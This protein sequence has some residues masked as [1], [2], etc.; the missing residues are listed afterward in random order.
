MKSVFYNDIENRAYSIY[1]LYQEG[2][3]SNTKELKMKVI[4]NNNYGGRT[5]STTENDNIEVY[6]GT[7]NVC[8]E[9]FTTV[10][11]LKTR[12]IVDIIFRNQKDINNKEFPYEAIIFDDDGK[13]RLIDSKIRD[14]RIV[15][16][17]IIFCSR[18]ILS[19]EIGHLFNGHCDYVKNESESLSYL[20]IV[21]SPQELINQ[22]ITAL[23]YRTMEMDADAFA[24]TDSYKELLILYNLFEEKVDPKLNIRPIDLFYWWAFAIRSQS[25]ITQNLENN[26]YFLEMVN[27]PS[28]VRWTKISGVFLKCLESG[29]WKIQYRVGDN[30]EVLLQEFVNGCKDAERIFNEINNTEY[31]WVDEIENGQLYDEFGIDVHDNWIELRGKLE[32]YS[33]LQ[34]Y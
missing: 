15:G 21:L 2:L 23:D 22:K 30:E 11:R 25:L 24:V 13:G 34:L 6:S 5:W 20:P 26:D 16:L 3:D 7:I 29:I 14:S 4:N 27:L 12:E 8:Y 33:R 10:M 31:N 32:K 28:V 1:D 17:L 19:H 18:F 9:Y